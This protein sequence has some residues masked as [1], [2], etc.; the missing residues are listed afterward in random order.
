MGDTIKVQN[1]SALL[2]SF[3]VKKDSLNKDSLNIA[4]KDSSNIHPAKSKSNKFKN[5]IPWCIIR[6]DIYQ[7][8][9]MY[10]T[11][12][13]INPGHG[14]KLTKNR[15]AMGTHGEVNGKT[16]WEKDI[17]DKIAKN[18]KRKLEGLG[19][20]VLYIDNTLVPDIQLAKNTQQPDAFISFHVDA[21]DAAGKLTK[22]E[23]IYTNGQE[24]KKL[25]KYVNENLKKDTRIRNNGINT[26]WGSQLCVLKGDTTIAGI[27][28]EG[29]FLTNKR[30]AKL[31]NSQ[32]YQD[33]IAQQAVDG[34]RE[35]LNA[36]KAAEKVVNKSKKPEPR[37]SYNLIWQKTEL[38]IPQLGKDY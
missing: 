10:N 35:Y 29:G 28:V 4:A 13:M 37:P 17:N 12:V 32:E 30:E 31:L 20:R 25:A 2:Y 18:A 16:V 22:G 14:E 33:F 38:L 1:N 3:I 24:G 15:T 6:H 27:L 36:K 8:L 26:N 11:V 9:P 34:V 7:K 5:T 23:T 19:A 21:P